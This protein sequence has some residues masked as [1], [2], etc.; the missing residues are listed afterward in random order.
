[1]EASGQTSGAPARAGQVAGRVALVTGA[2]RGIGRAVARELAARGARLVIAARTTDALAETAAEITGLGSSETPLALGYDV[3]D[4]AATR[5]AFQRVRR[6][7]GQLDILVCCAGTMT[8]T[9]I[10]MITEGEITSLLAINVASVLRHVQLAARLMMPRKTG[11]IVNVSSIAG[12]H[13]SRG[14]SAYSASKAAIIGATL[15]AAQE[16]AP[17]GIRVNAVAPGLIDTA[18]AK[19]FPEKARDAAVARIALGRL[20]G[21]D[22]VARAVCFLASDDASYVT[23]QV[24]GVDGGM[25]MG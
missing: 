11:A 3:V 15:S 10:G 2:S 16:L 5:D 24:L 21:A 19:I 17:F 22:E 14:Q 1:M 13:G 20:G 23:G 9:P 12:V 4:E 7:R 8:I 18:M 6:E 25:S